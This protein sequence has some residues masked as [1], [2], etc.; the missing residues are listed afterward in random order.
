MT[1]QLLQKMKRKWKKDR[2]D[3]E[4]KKIQREEKQKQVNEERKKEDLE[5]EKILQ[6][7][8][9]GNGEARKS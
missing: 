2:Q 9:R 8:R 6:T 5:T 7:I 1:E 4:E 3:E